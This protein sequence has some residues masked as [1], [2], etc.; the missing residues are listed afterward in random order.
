MSQHK[1]QQNPPL[2][3]FK[4]ILTEHIFDYCSIPGKNRKDSGHG[5]WG[6]T[7][8]SKEKFQNQLKIP[9]SKK[10]S[11]IKKNGLRFLVLKFSRDVAQ[12]CGIYRGESLF[13]KGKAANI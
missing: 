1:K 11:R 5:I 10:N 6:G 12:I 3:Y 2:I 7:G 13:S 9:E 8:K 4:I